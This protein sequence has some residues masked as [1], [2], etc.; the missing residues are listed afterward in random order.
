MRR[1]ILLLLL[2]S[3]LTFSQDINKPQAS[4]KELPPEAIPSG[5]CKGDMSGYLGIDSGEKV[6]E[7]KFSDEQIGEY[8]RIRLSQGYSVSLYPQ[9]SGKIYAICICHTPKP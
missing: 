3:S 4:V 2:F 8:V 7:T 9:A 6:N 1:L 5:T